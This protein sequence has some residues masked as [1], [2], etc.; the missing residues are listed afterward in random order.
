MEK[1]MDDARLKEI[2]ETTEKATPGPWQA[3]FRVLN[4]VLGGG[5]GD[6]FAKTPVHQ[7]GLLNSYEEAKT[8][9]KSDAKFIAMARTAIPELLAYIK[10]MTT[11]LEQ[12]QI[13]MREAKKIQVDYFNQIEAMRPVCEAANRIHADLTLDQ[14]KA[15][16]PAYLKLYDKLTD[17]LE[18]WREV[19]GG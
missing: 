14:R 4:A 9:A 2:K 12:K 7:Y 19:E 16:N 10:D 1:I 11:Q 8:K 3:E 5:S 13:V 18:A 17:A 15:W 6:V